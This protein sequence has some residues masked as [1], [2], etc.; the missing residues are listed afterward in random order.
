VKV[1]RIF[2]GRDSGAPIDAPPR[3][4]D[5]LVRR[6]LDDSKVYDLAGFVLSLQEAGYTPEPGMPEWYWEKALAA[7]RVLG[8]NLVIW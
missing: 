5:E 1:G 3:V 6:R 2:F 8:K 4:R 7:A